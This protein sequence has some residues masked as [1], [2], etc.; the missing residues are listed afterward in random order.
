MGIR[1][2]RFAIVKQENLAAPSQFAFLHSA[3][4][5]ANLRSSLRQINCL[6]TFTFCLLVISS[7][8]RTL[9]IE[10]LPNSVPKLQIHSNGTNRTQQGQ[11]AQQQKNY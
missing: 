7:E 3:T 5:F 10:R 11:V 1:V 4:H 9:E 2:K 8:A 6:I